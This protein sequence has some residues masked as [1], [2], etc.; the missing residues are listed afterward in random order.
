MF[1]RL[2]K[3]KGNAEQNDLQRSQTMYDGSGP[4]MSARNRESI[5]LLGGSNRNLVN[6]GGLNSATNRGSIKGM[7]KTFNFHDNDQDDLFRSQIV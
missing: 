7:P 4:L 6:E 5:T 3:K 2:L 1:K